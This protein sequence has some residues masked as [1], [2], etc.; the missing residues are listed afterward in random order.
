MSKKY[1]QQWQSL[2][3]KVT[4]IEKNLVR[5]ERLEVLE[6]NTQARFKK[7]G[8][9]TSANDNTALNLK[10]VPV[11]NKG[12]LRLFI[13]YIDD[14][15]Y[16]SISYDKKGWYWS[17]QI[18]GKEEIYQKARV[19]APRSESL[20][21]LLISMNADGQLDVTNNG[22]NLFGIVNFPTGV[23]D[24]LRQSKE[25]ILELESTEDEKF[26]VNIVADDQRNLGKSE[27]DQK[28][29][30]GEPIDDSHVQYDTLEAENLLITIDTAYPRI[31]ES[32][33]QGQKMNGQ[34][35]P[36]TEVKM[37][38]LSYKPTVQYKKVDSSTAKYHLTV[39]SEKEAVYAELTIQIK[40]EGNEIHFDILNINNLNNP[41]DLKKLI[42][43]IEFPDNYFV[44]VSSKEKNSSFDGARMSTNTHISGDTHLEVSNPMKDFPEGYMYGFVSNEHVV[45]GVWSNSHYNY[46][47]SNYRTSQDDHTR[48]TV[49]KQTIED[50]NFV[51]I[52]SSPWFYERA[53]KGQRYPDYTED[54]PSA[55]IVFAKDLNGD[56]VVD[57]QDGAIAYR[58][59]MNNPYGSKNVPDIMSYRVVMNFGSQAQNPF[60]KTL[61]GI[62]KVSLSTD[63]LGQGLLLKGYGNEGHDSAHLNYADIGQRIGGIKDFKILM[64]EAR[65]Y[66]ANLGIHINVTETYP[67]SPYFEPDILSTFDSGKFNYGW[68]WLD[69][70]IN[71]DSAYDLA[72]DRYHRLK[73]LKEIVGDGLEFI[74]VDVWGNGNSG[75]ESAWPS[76]QLAKE[77]NNLDW[78]LALEW[79][80]AAEYD[81]TF[82]HWAVDFNYGGYTLKGMN[83]KIARFIRNHQKDVWMGDIPHYG[84]ATNNP[85]L[86]GYS[87]QDF[88]GW[89]GRSHY[90]DYIQNIFKINLVT[91]FLQHFTVSIWIQGEEI[92]M[93]DNGETYLWTPEMEI[94][95]MDEKK[96]NVVV[97]RLSNELNSPDYQERQIEFNN[98]TILNRS[99]YLVP[100]NWDNQ[101]NELTG[102]KQK[103]YYFNTKD[104]E[105]EWELLEQWRQTDYLYLYQLTDLGKTE[106]Q[107]VKIMNGRITLNLPANMP[108]VI[109]KEP[110]KEEQVQWSEGMHLVDAGF[111]SKSLEHWN[112]KGE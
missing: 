105:T 12:S 5:Y 27:K 55:K 78:R 50:T 92:E 20:N 109:Y 32:I 101:G 83:S 85:L 25:V 69:Q 1:K 76:H 19:K 107:K 46:S 84:G 110:Q 102:D 14:K 59:I 6:N 79:S 56:G 16:M 29:D 62:K 58:E 52:T 89:Q 7:K 65:K 36:L 64:E 97:K 90:S 11:N 68:N 95:L 108:Y 70:A 8:F 15:N 44:S 73:D 10:F 60:L 24:K 88:E 63:G 26:S 80:H 77:I 37:N 103:L 93:T 28:P 57:W 91:R 87:L 81:G 51:G 98:R 38:G 99:A 66:G 21:E 41:N 30:Q 42:E 40:L 23:L 106:E 18:D 35:A 67:E 17:Y 104:E 3:S 86:G 31:K 75:D 48:L 72:N 94:H 4:V 13:H 22:V 39:G 82:H 34:A 49:T 33:Y 45:A 2:N 100:W 61:D 71:I 43:T 53:H 54:L 74:Y 96:N 111:N 47:V 9:T 112:I